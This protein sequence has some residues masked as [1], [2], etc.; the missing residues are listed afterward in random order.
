[1]KKLKKIEGTKEMEKMV[2]GENLSNETRQY[3]YNFQQFETLRSSPKNNFAVEINLNYADKEQSN[4]SIEVV[5]FN[6]SMKPKDIERKKQNIAAFH[7]WG[8]GN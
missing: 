7:T 6:Y 8:T 2:K 5:E 3:V 1:M 4:L